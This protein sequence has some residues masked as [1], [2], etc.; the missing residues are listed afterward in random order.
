MKQSVPLNFYDLSNFKADIDQKYANSIRNIVETDEW[1]YF[2]FG[3]KGYAKNVY[4]SK[5]LQKSFVSKPYP[6]LT[7]Q[8]MPWM[9][10]SKDENDLIALIEPRIVLEDLNEIKVINDEIKTIKNVLRNTNN[11]DNHLV[12]R[13]KMKKY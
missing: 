4:Y 13:C 3:Y 12:V 5:K 8:I 10:N 7:N 6:R 1:L 11:N 2:M 9:I